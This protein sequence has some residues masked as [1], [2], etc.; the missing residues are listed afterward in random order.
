VGYTWAAC[1]L[2]PPPPLWAD[3]LLTSTIVLPRSDSESEPESSVVGL[4]QSDEL[5]GVGLWLLRSETGLL[6]ASCVEA[7]CG[8]PGARAV[9]RQ[10]RTHA[11]HTD[12]NSA[13]ATQTVGRPPSL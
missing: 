2:V 5:Y 10:Q 13:S 7:A 12:V 6:D 3:I 4:P 9:S 11:E 8:V 1:G